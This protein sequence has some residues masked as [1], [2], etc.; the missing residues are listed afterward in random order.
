MSESNTRS[1]RLI[2]LSVGLALTACGG[3]SKKKMEE[4]IVESLD[5][6]GIEVASVECPGGQKDEAGV[7]FTCKGE[8]KSGTEFEVEVEAQGEG[9][10]K[11]D[12]VGVVLS[13]DK[14]EDNLQKKYDKDYDCGEPKK[15]IATKGTEVV[16]T[17]DSD[18]HTFTMTD[19]E[20][21]MELDIDKK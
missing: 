2:G 4:S 14:L 9:A 19:N 7:E 10:V 15:L 21:G 5:K 11:T 17:S 1:V 3:L 18:D 12:L 13:A 6:R 8:T 20:G 16:C